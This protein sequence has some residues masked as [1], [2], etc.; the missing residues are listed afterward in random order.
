M[1]LHQRLGRYQGEETR[2]MREARYLQLARAK[3]G[4][5]GERRFQPLCLKVRRIGAHGALVVLLAD[6]SGSEARRIHLPP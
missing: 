2:C 6:L 4:G 1:P 5:K 3:G